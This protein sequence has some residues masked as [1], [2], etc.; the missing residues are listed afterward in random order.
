MKQLSRASLKQI[1]GGNE[2]PN[3]GG[4]GRCVSCTCGSMY[5]CWYTTG[6][7][8]SLCD[9]VYPSCQG[10]QSSADVPCNGCTMN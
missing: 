5:S 6:S 10:I 1:K 9:R 7:A 2:V 4:S 8:S 3:D